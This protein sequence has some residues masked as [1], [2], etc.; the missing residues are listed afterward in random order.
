[1]ALETD[2]GDGQVG[3]D[4]TGQDRTGRDRTGQ[5]RAGQGRNGQVRDCAFRAAL[6][7]PFI[8]AGPDGAAVAISSS[9]ARA[10]L[11]MTCLSPG[12]AMQRDHLSKLLWPGR[13]PA[14]AL[15]CGG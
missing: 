14:Q 10:L 7:G 8:L 9:R 6:F 2:T 5:G 1:M 3:Q 4:L 11:A 15:I 12:E 13:F